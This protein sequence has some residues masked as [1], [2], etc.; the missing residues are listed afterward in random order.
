MSD[1]SIS[2]V[3]GI[4]EDISKG[5]ADKIKDPK[6]LHAALKNYADTSNYVLPMIANKADTLLGKDNEVEPQLMKALDAGGFVDDVEKTVGSIGTNLAKI[7]KDWERENTFMGKAGA[8]AADL[9]GKGKDALG[10][11]AGAV[12]DAGKAA[13]GGV[14]GA[15]GAAAGAIGKAGAAAKGAVTPSARPWEDPEYR[16]AQSHKVAGAGPHDPEKPGDKK[17]PFGDPKATS[18]TKAFKTPNQKAGDDFDVYGKT[19]H[20]MPAAGSNDQSVGRLAAQG[21]PSSSS[22]P[23]SKPSAGSSA[24]T[25]NISPP[26]AKPTPPGQAMPSTFGPGKSNDPWAQDDEETARIR[27]W[28]KPNVDRIRKDLTAAEHDAIK[29]ANPFMNKPVHKWTDDEMEKARELLHE[30]AGTKGP[31]WNQWHGGGAGSTGTNPHMPAAGSSGTQPHVPGAKTA[32]PQGTQVGTHQKDAPAKTQVGVHQKDAPPSKTQVGVHQK[33][34]PSPWAAADASVNKGQPPAGSAWGPA[35]Q[36]T[37]AGGDMD[38][39]L[40]AA[41]EPA[42]PAATAPKKEPA[43]PAAAPAP[44]KAPVDK[45]PKPLS[46]PAA[47]PASGPVTKPATKTN[48]KAVDPEAD[49]FAALNQ[50]IDTVKKDKGSDSNKSGESEEDKKK[51]A[52]KKS[53]TAAAGRARAGR[54]ASSNA[55]SAGARKVRRVNNS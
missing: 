23:A 22:T 29:K 49:A 44:K 1:N 14:K 34:L 48:I 5:E 18:I 43:K 28:Q 3:F 9:Y 39:A 17:L 26:G 54:V 53:A 7:Q 55:T 19:A 42:K 12:G 15:A 11:A 51:A 24:G 40:K 46:P 6:S 50:Q 35:K 37:D 8:K 2:K 20:N 32:V 31:L 10:K 47:K 38:A 13:I 30:P 33:D 16:A 27:K 21:N 36:A 45:S 4:N 41:P 52:A 25:Q